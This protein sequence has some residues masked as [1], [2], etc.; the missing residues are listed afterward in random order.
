MSCSSCKTRKVP[1]TYWLQFSPSLLLSLP[2]LSLSW[3]SLKIF[4]SCYWRD[5]QTIVSKFQGSLHL[6]LSLKHHEHLYTKYQLFPPRPN[7]NIYKQNFQKSHSYRLDAFTKV[8]PRISS[9]CSFCTENHLSA[10]VCVW[11]WRTRC[12]QPGGRIMVLCRVPSACYHE[13]DSLT[14]EPQRFT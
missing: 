7:A 14:S 8:N 4:S 2:F 11:V 10:E 13:T 1:E 12:R 3:K 6:F 9:D 5:F